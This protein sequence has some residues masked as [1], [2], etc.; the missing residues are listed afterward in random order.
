MPSAAFYGSL[1]A[2]CALAPVA[3]GAGQVIMGLVR[4]DSTGGR[5]RRRAS[6]AT[7]CDGSR[8]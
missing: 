4:E 2:V 6:A 1:I 5:D 3:T 7:D 8:R